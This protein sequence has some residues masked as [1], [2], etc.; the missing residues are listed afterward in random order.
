MQWDRV[1]QEQF[2][3]ARIMAAEAGVGDVRKLHA[4]P[5]LVVELIGQRA[6]GATVNAVEL[7]R[8]ATLAAGPQRLILLL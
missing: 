1:S 4:E 3:L 2:I 6:P 8:G 5:G 7:A